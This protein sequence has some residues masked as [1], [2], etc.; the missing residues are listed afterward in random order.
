MLS[1][2]LLKAL[3]GVLN[4]QAN[5]IQLTKLGAELIYE[6]RFEKTA[7]TVSEKKQRNG[8][9]KDE[10]SLSLGVSTPS[11]DVK[12]SAKFSNQNCQ[13]VKEGSDFS[14]NEGFE[15]VKTVSRGSRPTDISKWIGS[16]FTP[17]P[18]KR[19][20]EDISTLFK[21]NWMTQSIAYGFQRDLSGSNITAMYNKYIEKYCA[22]IL[23]GI[24]DDNCEVIGKFQ[25][26][27]TL[28]R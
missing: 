16:S 21:N 22:L 18:I 24:L 20:L 10:A 15:A 6:R 19:T 26:S 23:Y 3:G 28:L 14:N 8:C 2:P 5:L 17:I 27:L 13:G 7:K 11:V 1:K 25:K 4:F 9:V 12:G